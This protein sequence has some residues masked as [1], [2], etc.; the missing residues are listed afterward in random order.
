MVLGRARPL[1]HPLALVEPAQELVLRR[2]LLVADVAEF[3]GREDVA[4]RSLALVIAEQYC[5]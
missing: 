5:F 1:L 3:R 4:L 2:R